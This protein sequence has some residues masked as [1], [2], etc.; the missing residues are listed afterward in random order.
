MNTPKQ[1][2][3]DCQECQQGYF[4]HKIYLHKM[5]NFSKQHWNHN[6]NQFTYGYEGH[7]YK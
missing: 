7:A 2:I 1:I 3:S 6:Y 4:M 5:I